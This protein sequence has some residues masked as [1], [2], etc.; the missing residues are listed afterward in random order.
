MMNATTVTQ[1]PPQVAAPVSARGLEARMS[2]LQ[3]SIN[4]L[5]GE[6]RGR[7]RKALGAGNDALLELDSALARVAHD[8]WTL[9]GLRRR[10]NE[11]RARAETL[12][13]SAMKRAGELP[14]TAVSALATRTR[15]PIQGLARELDR[16]AKRIEK[17]PPAA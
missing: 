2:Q 6:A 4:K 12:G 15:A 16:L 1:E 14:G 10:L 11:L 5:E 3:A 9:T 13:E 7:L 17:A 8:D